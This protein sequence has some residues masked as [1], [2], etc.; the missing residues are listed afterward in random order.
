MEEIDM[1][2]FLTIIFLAIFVM[3]IAS[4]SIAGANENTTEN[5]NSTTSTPVETAS[6]EQ[7][8]RVGP[9]VSLRPLNS[10]IN[11]TQE[12]IIEVYFENPSLNDC[13]LEVDMKVSVPSDILYTCT[14]W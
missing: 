11:K 5:T 9:T 6:K 12:G 13:T 7:T 14:G 8:F 2:R 4:S 3:S 10:E 1:R